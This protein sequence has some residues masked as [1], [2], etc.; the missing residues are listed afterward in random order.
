M[1]R[2][3]HPCKGASA[4]RRDYA[5]DDAFSAHLHS[6]RSATVRLIAMARDVPP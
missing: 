5:V 3:G 6:S 1:D 4:Q 2:F